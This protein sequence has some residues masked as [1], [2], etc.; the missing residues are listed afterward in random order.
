VNP[1]PNVCKSWYYETQASV[2]A[3]KR[4]R[5]WVVSTPTQ[6]QRHKTHKAKR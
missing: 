3:T 5:H 4:N 1:G 2:A 6:V